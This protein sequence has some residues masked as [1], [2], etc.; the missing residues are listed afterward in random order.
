M[1][2]HLTNITNWKITIFY[3]KTHYKCPFT[4][5]MLNYQRVWCGKIRKGT[6]TSWDSKSDSTWHKAPTKRSWLATWGIQ[7]FCN[8]RIPIEAPQWDPERFDFIPIINIENSLFHYSHHFWSWSSWKI[9][10][11]I[12][13]HSRQRCN[14]Q[15][16][17][18]LTEWLSEASDRHDRNLD[19]WGDRGQ[20]WGTHEPKWEKSI[21]CHRCVDLKTHTVTYI[22]YL[23]IIYI[24]TMIYIY[25]H[26]TKH[27]VNTYNIYTYMSCSPDDNLKFL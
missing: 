6:T 23:F 21:D 19:P 2:A 8:I 9:S 5:A 12:R 16:S 15:V 14:W 22:S 13:H 26:I 3:G 25:T 10:E 1:P 4:I 18:Y 17:S 7:C 20:F 24:Y 27:I 11:N